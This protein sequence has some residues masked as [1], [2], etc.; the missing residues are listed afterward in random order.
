MLH[1]TTVCTFS[2]SEL[3]KV[4]RD[5]QFLTFLAS[6][7]ASRHNSVRFF[8]LSTSKTAPNL[9]CFVHFDLN[10]CFAPQRRALFRHLTFQKW[11]GPG[12]FCTVWLGNMLR[13]TTA[14]HLNSQKCSAHEV[15]IAFH[16]Q[17]CFAQ[18][19]RAT[20][21]LSCGQMAPHLPL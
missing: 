1:A 14:W 2:T 12:V 11:S 5:R 18:Q 9:L 17:T 8:D 19:Q 7:C 13:A 6:K 4:L 16:L 10:M 20:F 15:C 21:H 3:P